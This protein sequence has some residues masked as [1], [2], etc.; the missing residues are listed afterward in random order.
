[1]SA[2]LTAATWAA[3]GVIAAA[4]GTAYTADQSRSAANRANDI[5]KANAKKNLQLQDE[6]TNKAN[7]KSPDVLAMMAANMLSAKSGNASTML[8]GPTGVDAGQLTLGR[9]SLLGS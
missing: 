8:T 3:I 2:T 6:A 9:N 4:A 1:M 7:A 5:A